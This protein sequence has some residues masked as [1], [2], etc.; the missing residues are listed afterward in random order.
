[1]IES[2]SIK[3]KPVTDKMRYVTQGE[4]NGKPRGPHKTPSRSGCTM[5]Y[6]NWL[7]WTR[8]PWESLELIGRNLLLH[9]SL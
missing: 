2:L 5:Q 1:M 4:Y 3:H 7:G 8:L 6:S 9:I